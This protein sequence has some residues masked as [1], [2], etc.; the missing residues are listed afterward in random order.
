MEPMKPVTITTVSQ[1]TDV[2]L[3]TGEFLTVWLQLA[4]PEDRAIQVG[5][6]IT[7]AGSAEVYLNPDDLRIVKSFDEWYCP[8]SLNNQEEVTLQ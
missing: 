4:Q 8:A 5:L 1:V 3:H 2:R 7:P 6:R